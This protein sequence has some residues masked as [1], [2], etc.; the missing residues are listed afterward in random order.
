MKN[1]RGNAVWD[2]IKLLTV[3]V[4]LIVVL[5]VAL[6][7]IGRVEQREQAE[8]EKRVEDTIKKAVINCYAIEGAYPATLEYIEEHYGLIVDRERY[9]VFYEIFADNIMPEIAVIPK[10]K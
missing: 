3:P 4:I 9:D 6:T 1:R 10:Y 7:A 8:N 2:M 5:C